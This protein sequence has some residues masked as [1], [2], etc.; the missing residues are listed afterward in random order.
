MT[1]SSIITAEAARDEIVRYFEDHP[2]TFSAAMEQLDDCTGILYDD[3]YYE[4]DSIDDVLVGMAPSDIVRMIA[5]GYDADDWYTNGC[6]MLVNA[7]FNM[8][9]KY[10]TYNGY[11]NLVSTDRRDYSSYLNDESI[12]EML[13]YRECIDAIF[14]DDTLYELF[15]AMEE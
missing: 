12:D 7:R 13:E 5:F 9:R 6:G 15:G 10:F 14:G 8:M 3:R 4:M 1:T 2:D 11:G